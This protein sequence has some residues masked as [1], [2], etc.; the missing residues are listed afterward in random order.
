VE[1]L[2]VAEVAAR[3]GKSEAAVVA[4]TVTLHPSAK[5]FDFSAI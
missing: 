3:L 4:L 1:G 2:S 5:I